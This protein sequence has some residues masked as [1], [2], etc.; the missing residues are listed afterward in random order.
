MLGMIL[1]AA[2]VLLA[3]SILYAQ[4]RH[5]MDVPDAA[6]PEP[7]QHQ[8]LILK[9][10]SY[11]LVLSYKVVGSIVR[12]RSAERGGE[13]EEIPLAL[14]DIPAT[15]R[16]KREHEPGFRNLPPVLSPELAK[17]E[18][19][20]AARTPTIAPDLRLPEEDSVLAL[21]TFQAT[22]E[23]VPLPQQATDLNKET[24]HAVQKIA[25]NPASSAHR[26]AD[27]R[28][29]KSEIQLHVADPVFY[30]R[31]GSDDTFIPSGSA[32]TVD[33]HGA[34]T[35]GR[36]TPGA[37]A[38]GS[39]YVIERVDVRY[40]SRQVDS[41]R[42]MQLGTG[43]SQ[44]DVIEMKAEPLPGG[45]WLKLTPLAPLEFGEYALIEVLSSHELNLDVWDFGVHPTAPEN[46]EAQRPEPHH[47]P[48]LNH[49]P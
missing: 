11:Q 45:Q 44:P 31:I 14:V 48:S 46:V 41:F 7:P 36:A 6:Q 2:C 47:A 12:Y 25:I 27:M 21:D 16:W 1:C 26:I 8:R 29:S 9:D 38:P 19:A 49:R 35:A 40:D 37:G 15:E 10:G 24:A 34:S 39:T 28:G 17:E 32:I 33:T 42:I 3:S 4:D 20:R 5:P 30:V 13:Q 18:A 43:H 23:L 22:P